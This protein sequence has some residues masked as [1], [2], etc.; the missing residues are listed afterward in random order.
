MV[1]LVCG[2]KTDLNWFSSICAFPLLSLTSLPDSFRGATPILSV[3]LH[4]IYFQNGLLLFDSRP[5]VMIL[6]I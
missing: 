5:S 1:S 6:L 2:V 4:L 3:F